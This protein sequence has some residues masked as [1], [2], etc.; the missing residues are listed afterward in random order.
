MISL[1]ARVTS[2]IFNPYF[3]LVPVPYLLVLR[4]T[5]STEEAVEWSLFSLAFLLLLG[6]VVYCLVQKRYFSDLDISKKEQRPYFFLLMSLFAIGYFCGLFYFRGPVVLF[7]SLSGVFFS[8]L[9]FSFLITRI[10][11][12]IHVATITAMIF[13][14]SVLYG[15]QFLLL[16][17][18]IP[19]IGWSRIHARR[20]T[21]QEVIAGGII[22]IIIPVVMF[23]VFKVL[24]N[25][26]LS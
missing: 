5:G 10:K 1:I 22:G 17:F 15:G 24:L 4:Q 2:F 16:L 7:I 6:I 12:S 25:I 3:L 21:H 8:L 9:V 19:L 20:H 11:A 23:V 13:S 26:S 14:L 18:L